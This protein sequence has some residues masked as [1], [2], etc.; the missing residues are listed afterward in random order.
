MPSLL[1]NPVAHVL[2]SSNACKILGK[3]AIVIN[4]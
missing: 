2:F 1:N 3:K 4:Q